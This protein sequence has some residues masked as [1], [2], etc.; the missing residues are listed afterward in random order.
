[1]IIRLECLAMK[2]EKVL[3]GML[4]MVVGKPLGREILQENLDAVEVGFSNLEKQTP[5]LNQLLDTPYRR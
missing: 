1:M 5:M 4:K 3:S 2:V